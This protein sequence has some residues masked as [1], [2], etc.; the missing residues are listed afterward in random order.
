MPRAT[1]AQNTAI[2]SRRFSPP[3]KIINN[4]ADF[5]VQLTVRGDPSSKSVRPA[6]RFAVAHPLD[7]GQEF[8]KSLHSI[9]MLL[10]Y[11]LY[12]GTVYLLEVFQ[13]MFYK[14][15]RLL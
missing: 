11:H 4:G 7:L 14:N 10:H 1:E 3:I 2:H 5:S 8:N 13:P 12:I 6:D 15:S 9:A